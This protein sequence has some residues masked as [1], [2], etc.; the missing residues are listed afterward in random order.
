MKM[1]RKSIALWLALMMCLFLLSACGANN[2]SDTEE[3]KQEE[4]NNT[5]T[6]FL[7]LLQEEYE[8]GFFQG[9][10]PRHTYYINM[11]PAFIHNGIVYV[12]MEYRKFGAYDIVSKE[13]N[14]NFCSFSDG[15]HNIRFIDGNFYT[16]GVDGYLRMCDRNGA[17]LN[18][19]CLKH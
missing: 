12:Q 5:G 13:F 9:E 1:K 2:T 10:G 18:N 3:A 8:N 19:V 11:M 15:Y 14:E 4:K 16:D 6:E 17:L 7:A